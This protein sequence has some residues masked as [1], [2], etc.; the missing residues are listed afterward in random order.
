MLDLLQMNIFVIKSFGLSLG[1]NKNT[2]QAH[3]NH[4]IKSRILILYSV[5]AI[6]LSLKLLYY[7]IIN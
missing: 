7:L 5:V 6:K 2:P 1:L 4:R 3:I